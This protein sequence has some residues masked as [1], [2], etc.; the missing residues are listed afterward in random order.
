[1]KIE[2]TPQVHIQAPFG[3]ASAPG[4][5]ALPRDVFEKGIKESRSRRV[6][7]KL[8]ELRN[9][10]ADSIKTSWGFG[11]R[12]NAYN[13]II[14]K[15]CRD[16]WG[17]YQPPLPPLLLKATI[18][19]ESSFN[20]DTVSPTGYVGLMQLG[21]REALSQGLKLEPIDERYIPEKNV[22]AGVGILQN[23]HKVMSNPTAQYPAEEW[24]RNVAEYY[25]KNGAPSDLQ[26][27]YL[28]LAAYNAGGG[29]ILRAM[30]YAIDRGKDPRAWLN[31][32]EPRD[33]PAESPLYKGIVDVYGD[34]YALAKYYETSRYPVKILHLAGLISSGEAAMLDVV[35][36]DYEPGDDRPVASSDWKTLIQ[37]IRNG[38][39][40]SDKDLDDPLPALV[41]LGTNKVVD[42]SRDAVDLP[43]DRE[44]TFGH[45]MVEGKYF[46]KSGNWADIG[47][48]VAADQYV[49][50]SAE[51]QEELLKTTGA[52]PGEI[53]PGVASLMLVASTENWDE[54]SG[55]RPPT[56]YK[57][58]DYSAI[59]KV[60]ITPRYIVMHYTANVKDTP[61]SVWNWFNKKKG[62]PSTQFIVGKQGDILQTMPE[63][64]KC[65]GTLDFN[66]ESVQIEVCG[67]FRE[68]KETDEEFAS[69]VALVKYIQKKYQIPDT[70]IISH[71]Q[72]D[73]N[74][75]H[76]GRKPDPG[77]RFMN[78][79]Y[80]ALR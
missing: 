31:L 45:R 29:T 30:D 70:N 69:A 28:S 14:L 9:L 5:P 67:N 23:K 24:A 40:E 25:A 68:E 58:I 15:A 20:P 22:P 8:D 71:R 66:K 62:K 59:G 43:P 4:S 53:T 80:D 73:N 75:G 12:E 17:S 55:P 1:M 77:F 6:E 64:Q 21:K 46:D 36:E 44:R 76:V 37:K 42:E 16:K 10:D 34:R 11:E 48:A 38:E 78:R 60:T 51:R 35:P 13:L 50:L 18:A 61:Q 72:V 56:T 65:S 54:M 32:I 3:R 79:L 19:K 74:F 63:T 26:K 47:T 49:G 33:K 57:E 27:W 52:K 7:K 39:L 2:Q 41:R